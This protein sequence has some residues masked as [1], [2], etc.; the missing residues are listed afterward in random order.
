MRMLLPNLS[1][2]KEMQ[3]V[4]CHGDYNRSASYS[5]LVDLLCW[6]TLEKRRLLLQVSLFYW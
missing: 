3:L 5:D 2:F 1:K 6:G 4:K